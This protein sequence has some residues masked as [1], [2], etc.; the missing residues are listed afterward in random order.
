MRENIYPKEG[1]VFAI[2]TKIQWG[3]LIFCKEIVLAQFV[4]FVVVFLY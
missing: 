4:F 3:V 1:D 2:V